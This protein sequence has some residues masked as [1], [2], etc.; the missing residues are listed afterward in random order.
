MSG[1]E[2]GCASKEETGIFSP[3]S[4]PLVCGFVE[5]DGPLFL[6]VSTSGE[7]RRQRVF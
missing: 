4:P 3:L 6:I 1:I 2:V 7:I 5:A